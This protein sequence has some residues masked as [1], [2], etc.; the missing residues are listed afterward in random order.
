MSLVVIAV[1]VGLF[2]C[3][4]LLFV[5]GLVCLFTAVSVVV[6]S[7]S[8]LVVPVAVGWLF[9]C[10]FVCLFACLLACRCCWFVAVVVAVV[11]VAAAVVVATV[12]VVVM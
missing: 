9:V 3:C 4:R 6:G 8:N 1:V 11:A 5:V 10:L 12:E 2:V 7:N